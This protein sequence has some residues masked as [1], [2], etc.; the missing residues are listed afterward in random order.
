MVTSQATV[1]RFREVLAANF[2]VRVLKHLNRCFPRECASLEEPALTQLVRNSVRRADH[3]G[4]VNERDVCKY[5]DL[6]LLFGSDFDTDPKLDWAQTIL[7]S[8]DYGD[9]GERADDLFD[10]GMACC[11]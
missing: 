4:F 1:D 5:V 11:G 2:E 8:P 3:Y 9:P 6:A 7:G 10:Q